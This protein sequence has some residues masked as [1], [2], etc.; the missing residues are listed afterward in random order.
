MKTLWNNFLFQFFAFLIRFWRSGSHL[1]I[2]IRL[3]ALLGLLLVHHLVRQ[4]SLLKIF[5]SI[6]RSSSLSSKRS[7][8]IDRYPGSKYSES[9]PGDMFVSPPSHSGSALSVAHDHP[10]YKVCQY[11]VIARSS[12]AH[13]GISVSGPESEHG[14]RAWQRPG[15]RELP[16]RDLQRPRHPQEAHLLRHRHH[17]GGGHVR[18]WLLGGG[19]RQARLPLP[20]GVY[21]GPGQEQGWLP[22]LAHRPAPQTGRVRPLHWPHGAPQILKPAQR[23][24]PGKWSQCWCWWQDETWPHKTGQENTWVLFLLVS[25]KARGNKN[26][27]CLEVNGICW[28]KMNVYAVHSIMKYF[29][30][31]SLLHLLCSAGNFDRFL[32]LSQMIPSPPP[33][34]NTS[35]LSRKH[36]FH[37]EQKAAGQQVR[38]E[39]QIHN[40]QSPPDITLFQWWMFSKYRN[41]HSSPSARQC[42][43]FT[44]FTF[45]TS[46]LDWHTRGYSH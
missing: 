41:G 9:F 24:A 17:D 33:P 40:I 22:V 15:L 7:M 3:G 35:T 44:K 6:E 31:P 27:S 1:L 14:T 16:H 34:V 28:V 11:R 38:I 29:Q 18:Q 21:R 32:C 20:H 36:Q 43:F 5:I 26:K 2:I 37:A 8:M 46:C 39:C 4:F 12:L 10:D 30:Y 25:V 23:L 19:H 45:I 13:H 42:P